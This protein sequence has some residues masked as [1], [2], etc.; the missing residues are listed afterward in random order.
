MDINPEDETSYTT[1][2]QEAFLKNVENENC[3]NY[4]SVPVN[5]PQSIWSNNLVPSTMASGSG[6]SSFDSY[7]LGSDDE[8]FLMPNNVADTT[9][10]RRDHAACLLTAARLYLNLPPETR[11]NWWQTIPD[12][13]DY[14][15]NPIEISSTFWISDITGWWHQ[16]EETTHTMPISP[17]WRTTY[18]L[19]YHMVSERRP[20]FPLAKMLSAGGKQKQLAIYF[21]HKSL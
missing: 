8:Q 2:Y 11:Q 16:Q 18:S 1:Q 3:P 9:P 6:H 12:H 21:T 7:D 13:N 10:G 15:S 5:R 20:V 4:R 19:L 14:H 17:M